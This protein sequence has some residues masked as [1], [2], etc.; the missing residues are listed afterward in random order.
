[1]DYNFIGMFFLFF[2]FIVFILSRGLETSI[3][4]LCLSHANC[5]NLEGFYFKRTD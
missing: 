3:L 1:M 4:F 2:N 5:K